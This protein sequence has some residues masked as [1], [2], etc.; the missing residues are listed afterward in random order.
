MTYFAPILQLIEMVKT[1]FQVAMVHT[2]MLD[3]KH[4]MECFTPI[5]AIFNLNGETLSIERVSPFKLK[6][7][8]IGVK[9]GLASLGLKNNLGFRRDLG[10]ASGRY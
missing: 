1:N 9:G 2:K 6:S 3:H 5:P 8:G 10:K 4:V 7:A